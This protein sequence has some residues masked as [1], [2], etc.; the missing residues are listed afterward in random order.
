MCAENSQFKWNQS[1]TQRIHATS[2]RRWVLRGEP[3]PDY[4]QR[5]CARKRVCLTGDGESEAELQCRPIVCSRS[6]RF[7][8][9]LLNHLL[10]RDNCIRMLKAI[11]EINCEFGPEMVGWIEITIYLHINHIIISMRA[12]MT[13]SIHTLR[14]RQF[15]CFLSSQFHSS[16]GI[17]YTRQIHNKLQPGDRQQNLV[18]R[19]SA[20][21]VVVC[22]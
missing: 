4:C 8:S 22:T 11:N 17:V 12:R 3:S 19:F 2:N 10:S 21:N 1:T 6:R 14:L 9:F 16:P 15:R 5:T 7:T 18:L 13:E 20:H